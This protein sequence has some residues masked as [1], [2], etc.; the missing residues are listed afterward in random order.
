MTVNLESVRHRQSCIV[1]NRQILERKDGN[2]LRL[3]QNRLAFVTGKE[4]LTLI[5]ENKEEAQ[6]KTELLAQQ[7]EP[8]NLFVVGGDGTLHSAINGVMKVPNHRSTLLHVIDLGTGNDYKR[9][10]D[11]Y[12]NIFKTDLI[13]IV[14]DH[15][16]IHGINSWCI[17]LDADIANDLNRFR[18][19]NKD[20]YLKSMMYHFCHYRP[21]SISYNVNGDWEDHKITML[22]I[23]NGMYYGNGRKIAPHAYLTDGTLNFYTVDDLNKLKIARLF[24]LLELGKH[25]GNP[26]VHARKISELVVESP[27]GLLNAN[28]DGES[29]SFKNCHI[30]VEH[31]NGIYVCPGDPFA[32]KEDIKKYILHK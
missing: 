27:N 15:Q 20:P 12:D 25:E 24:C 29:Y 19:K 16:T 21:Y 17:G 3:L 30:S 31:N 23:L 5:T 2:L 7:K 11:H 32:I 8:Y 22:A 14:S 9:T 1:I 4:P 10:I 6:L 28:I 26:H 13:K 18:G